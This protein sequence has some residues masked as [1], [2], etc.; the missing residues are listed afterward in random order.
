LDAEMKKKNRDIVDGALAWALEHLGSMGY[1]GKCYAF[2]EDAYELGGNITL[3]GQGCTAKEAAQVY[4]A[5]MTQARI[6]FEGVPPR[7]AYVF[8]DCSGPLGG[9]D[10]N[11]GHMGLSLGDGRVV[12]A[13]D[14]VRVDD[15]HAVEQLQPPPGWTLPHYTGWAAPEVILH[16]YC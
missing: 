1:L 4:L 8:Y 11:W 7:G 9:Q 3:D 5:R 14:R 16:G 15:L 13:W 10:R 12:H 6:A 2:C